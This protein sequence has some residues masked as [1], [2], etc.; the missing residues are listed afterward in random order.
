[1]LFL[2]NE[3]KLSLMRGREDP[4]NLGGICP[5]KTFSAH[6]LLNTWSSP[7]LGK[8]RRPKRGRGFEFQSCV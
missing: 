5:R 4:L 2:L 3:A 6:V 8:V 1:M 7:I